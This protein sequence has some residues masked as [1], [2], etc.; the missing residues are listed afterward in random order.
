MRSLPRKPDAK[1]YAVVPL[2]SQ[3]GVR[4]ERPREGRVWEWSDDESSLSSEGE[5]AAPIGKDGDEA[6]RRGAGDP[7]D[8]D[9]DETTNMDLNEEEMAEEEQRKAAHA[10]RA[11]TTA[12]GLERMLVRTKSGATSTSLAATSARGLPAVQRTRTL[13]GESPSLA[14]LDQSSPARRI[15]SGGVAT[16][17]SQSRSASMSL[18][19]SGALLSEAT[20]PSPTRIRKKNSSPTNSQAT[21]AR[22]RVADSAAK[23]A[24]SSSTEDDLMW[25]RSVPDALGMGLS[26]SPTTSR[27]SQTGSIRSPLQ[28]TSPPLHGPSAYFGTKISA[29]QQQDRRRSMRKPSTE[30]ARSKERTA[31][32]QVERDDDAM[33]YGWPSSLKGSLYDR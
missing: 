24:D 18:Q 29:E 31:K 21:E 26:L 2:P 5:E 30:G 11:T 20:K 1:G 16:S 12:A 13:D 4:P 14:T 15:A 10:K 22:S 33:D 9:E 32:K 7:G 17:P 28:P 23:Q 3:L 8:Q 27:T 19:P 6:Q 25:S